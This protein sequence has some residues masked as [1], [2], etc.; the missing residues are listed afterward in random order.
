VFTK[1][2]FELEVEVELGVLQEWPSKRWAGSSSGAAHTNN[3]LG[4]RP[5]ASVL[6]KHAIRNSGEL[7]LGV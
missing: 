7:E 4:I 5:I 6:Q 2:G 3:K 1:F